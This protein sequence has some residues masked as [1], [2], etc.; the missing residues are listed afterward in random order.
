MSNPPD[1][2]DSLPS[3][4][5][6]DRDSKKREHPESDLIATLRRME[7][8]ARFSNATNDPAP[9]FHFNNNKDSE[10]N[11]NDTGNLKGSYD[12]VVKLVS[13]TPMKSKPSHSNSKDNLGK[14]LNQIRNE[15]EEYAKLQVME[16][17][18]V[19][20]AVA[21]LVKPRN[22]ALVRFTT[23]IVHQVTQRLEM[24]L[25]ASDDS[26]DEYAHLAK[27][28]KQDNHEKETPMYPW[29]SAF[30]GFVSREI[31]LA[32]RESNTTTREQSRVNNPLSLLPFEKTNINPD[33]SDDYTRTDILLRANRRDV[34]GDGNAQ[35]LAA[36]PN[37]KDVVAVI[38]V[39]HLTSE[40]TQAFAQLIIYSRN[41]YANQHNRRFVWG[42]TICGSHVRACVLTSD[43][44]FASAIMDVNKHKGRQEF[45]SLLVNMSYCAEDQNQLGYDPTIRLDDR[46]NIDEIDVYDEVTDRMVP[47]KIVAMTAIATR[48]FGRH[49]RCYLCKNAAASAPTD[50]NNSSADDDYIVIKSAW[51]YSTRCAKD[52]SEQAEL[53]NTRPNEAMLMRRIAKGLQ[54]IDSVDGKYAKLIHGG[55]VRFEKCS[56][57]ATEE[58]NTDTAFGAVFSSDSKEQ[59]PEFRIN[60]RLAM[61]P[62][63]RP[64][65]N[66][67]NADQ[68]IVAVA[69]VMEAHT[70]IFKECRILHRDI[71]LNN[72]MFRDLDDG[73]VGGVLIG[74][75]CAKD[76]EA[77]SWETRPE[78]TGTLPYMSINNLEA[79]SLVK[80][81]QLDDWESLIYVL[82][83]LGT[84][85]INDDDGEAYSAK[86]QLPINAWQHDDP[87]KVAESKRLILNT[88]NSFFMTILSQFLKSEYSELSALVEDLYMVLFFNERLSLL[89]HG[90]VDVTRFNQRSLERDLETCLDK[91]DDIELRDPFERRAKYAEQIADDLLQ[92]ILEKR[93]RALER[94][95]KRNSQAQSQPAVS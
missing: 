64:L 9:S 65:Q 45:V 10:D 66:V 72:M 20:R 29:I 77:G 59:Q 57:G 30:F 32:H 40:E 28:T 61:T 48:C 14:S 70:A 93:S 36:K 33:G 39:K 16:K 85:G 79:A 51:A 5:K 67:A 91:D 88:P 44:I 68:L 49:T 46:G 12:H 90:T 43:D 73:S 17:L 55:T 47:Y 26:N 50:V 87:A 13:T 56:S 24:T 54:G 22:D 37:Y 31:G 3:T 69:D 62:W 86:K 19:D 60:Q 83:W 52:G 74:F 15:R 42:F 76:I 6:R 25:L 89:S 21:N 1:N 84:T 41:L 8:P 82:C 18:W 58:D 95:N 92:V 11:D 94:I 78:R 63:C 7:R 2:T 81:T 71:S 4:P 53:E 35:N 38:E 80:R 75:D 27:W 23:D 34:D